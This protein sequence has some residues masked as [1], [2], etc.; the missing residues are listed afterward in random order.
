MPEDLFDPGTAPRG[1]LPSLSMPH[2]INYFGTVK[3]KAWIPSGA[4]FA[5]LL[6]FTRKEQN[7]IRIPPHLVGRTRSEASLLGREGPCVEDIQ[8]FSENCRTHF[9]EFPTND[10]GPSTS[11]PE[12]PSEGL[13]LGQTSYKLGTLN[14]PW[15]GSNIVWLLFVHFEV[16]VNSYGQLLGTIVR[17]VGRL[18]VELC[19]G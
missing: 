8:H 15:Q 13:I 19:T 6:Y 16:D 14:G 1:S 4:L 11:H 17:K 5:S 10:V 2:E 18:E 3:A 7:V 12:A 9:A